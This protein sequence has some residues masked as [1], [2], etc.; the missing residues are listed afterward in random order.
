VLKFPTLAH[1]QRD[2]RAIRAEIANIREIADSAVQHAI[3]RIEAAYPDGLDH[4]RRRLIAHAVKP[5]REGEDAALRELIADL[6]GRQR[7]ELFDELLDPRL[8]A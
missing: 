8:L 4:E 6:T 2:L 3:N 1:G 5:L 7:R